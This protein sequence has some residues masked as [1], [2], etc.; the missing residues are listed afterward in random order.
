MAMAL[1][2]KGGGGGCGHGWW[3]WLL[4]GVV[5][6]DHGVITPLYTA[7]TGVLASYAEDS[8]SPPQP[9]D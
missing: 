5:G 4:G 7:V 2:V 8:Q 3:S 1:V 9:S 6:C